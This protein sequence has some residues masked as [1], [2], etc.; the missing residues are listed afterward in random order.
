[1]AVKVYTVAQANRVLPVVATAI[2]RL[3]A[4]FPEILRIQDRLSVLALLGG[5][6]EA[7][8]EHREFVAVREELE[9][10]VVRYNERLE[11][12]Q[13]IG[14][15]VKD[16][17]LGLVDFYARK[18]ARLVLLCWKLGEKRIQFWHELE[19]GFAGRRPIRELERDEDENRREA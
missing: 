16:L 2:R 5:E 12:L 17:N 13:R 19:A 14:C 6:G 11:Q 3:R 10:L 4:D 7:S 18:G 1:M 15:I 9:A 8:P